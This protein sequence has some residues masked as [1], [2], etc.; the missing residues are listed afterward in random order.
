MRIYPDGP[1]FRVDVHTLR[2]ELYP[3]V[4]G[5]P[6]GARPGPVSQQVEPRD[7]VHFPIGWRGV[8]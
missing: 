2:G 4:A 3:S 8:R 5:L 1:E 7:F 6:D